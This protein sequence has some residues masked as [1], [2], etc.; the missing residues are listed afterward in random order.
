[1]LL[2]RY[3]A[4]VSMN[5][6]DIFSSFPSGISTERTL[7]FQYNPDNSYDFRS[8]RINFCGRLFGD[9]FANQVATMKILV[10][11]APKVVAA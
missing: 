11:M 10:A 1:M 9:Y 2:L 8:P 4:F 6:D 5:T 3:S 7:S